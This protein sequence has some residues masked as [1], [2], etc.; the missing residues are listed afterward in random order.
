MPNIILK[1]DS[2]WADKF[3]KYDIFINNKMVSK[4][5]DNEELKLHHSKGPYSIYIKIDWKKS[6]M[7]SFELKT[8][9][10]IIDVRN[11]LRGNNL[12][13]YKS[14]IWGNKKYIDIKIRN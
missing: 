6:S 9:D 5:S 12:F 7:L 8:K 3:R 14:H 11:C 4:I 2:G 13:F 1:R 10:I